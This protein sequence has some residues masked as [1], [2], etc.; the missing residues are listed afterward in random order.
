MGIQRCRCHCLKLMGIEDCNETLEKALQG[1]YLFTWLDHVFPYLNCLFPHI[2]FQSEH[3]IHR[4]KM[5]IKVLD[6]LF[7]N[8]GPSWE[9]IFIKVKID[10]IWR[11]NSFHWSTG[12]F[13]ECYVF[14]DFLFFFSLFLLKFHTA[15][16]Q[17]ILISC[18]IY[19]VS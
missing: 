12:S 15:Q 7:T 2:C 6:H 10:R 3:I 5:W 19:R 18:D 14:S 11:W 8:A 4:P 13:C 1:V 16:A 17:D 9:R